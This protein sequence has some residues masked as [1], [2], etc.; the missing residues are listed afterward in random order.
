MSV[1]T[2]RGCVTLVSHSV[3]IARENQKDPVKW[4][5]QGRGEAHG[6][7]GWC[8]RLDMLQVSRCF[9]VLWS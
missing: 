8:I 6:H 9:G 1:W 5:L 7:G 3:A 2:C 4:C